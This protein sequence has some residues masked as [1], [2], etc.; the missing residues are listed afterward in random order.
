MQKYTEANN[1]KFPDPYA[2]IVFEEEKKEKKK[3]K[4]KLNN[5]VSKKKREID[6]NGN[7]VS[8]TLFRPSDKRGHLAVVV[9]IMMTSN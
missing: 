7:R 2:K 4:K 3:K 8:V 5:R 6:A 1:G 9:I